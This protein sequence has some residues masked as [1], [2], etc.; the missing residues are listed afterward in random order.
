MFNAL[1][2]IAYNNTNIYIEGLEKYRPIAAFNFIGRYRLVDFPISNM[3]NSGMWDIDIYVNG[4]PKVL[5][6]H[7]G[8]GRH[9]N[10]NS[11]HGHLGLIPVFPDG[12]RANAVPD[13]EMY[14]DNLVDIEN[15]PNDYVII[16]P[17]NFIYKANYSDLLDQHVAS[18]ADISMLYQRIDDAKD[19]YLHCDVLTLNK[20]KGV[21][22]I[23]ENLG[24]YKVRNLSLATYIMSK[25]VFINLVKK[26]RTTSSMYWLKDIIND[27]CPDMDIRAINYRGRIYPI[28]NQ[29]SYFKSNMMM[30]HEDNM[31]DFSDAN[32]PIYTR[33]YD[34]A[35][36]IYLNDG[37]T[38]NTYVSNGCQI[39][40]EITNS[41]IGR[42]VKIGKNAKVDGCII[43]PEAVVGDN[44]N[45]KNCI[46]DK[47]ARIIHKKDLAGTEE[48]PLYIGRRETV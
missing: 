24:A 15:D 34:S 13:V 27:S 31:K 28:Y 2:I 46:I 8:S 35:P 32:W 21:L 38:R 19:K 10:I 17:V 3:T 20:Q 39:S 29:E 33:T 30:L 1:G 14:Y 44:A 4:N 6:E 37:T 42:A 40:G 25:E 26:A 41:I 11:K 43:L 12:T 47:G 23:E 22:G 7:I 18:G 48:S 9:Y 5:F 16:A 36:T 45:L